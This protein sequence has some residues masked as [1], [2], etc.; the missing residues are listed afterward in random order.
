MK[1]SVEN[2]TRAGEVETAVYDG[3]Y[4][5]L[6]TDKGERV[7]NTCLTKFDG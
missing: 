1:E 4:M 2:V 5:T 3:R 6:E 7:S